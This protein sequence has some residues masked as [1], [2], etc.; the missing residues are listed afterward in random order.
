MTAED[1]D[2]EGNAEEKRPVEH[3]PLHSAPPNKLDPKTPKHS[4]VATSLGDFSKVASKSPRANSR[5]E[6][7]SADADWLDIQYA[8][9]LLLTSDV[10]LQKH[11]DRKKLQSQ[12]KKVHH[13]LAHDKVGD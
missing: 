10:D 7:R 12:L 3:M 5:H 9:G 8:P 13:Q 11:L 1:F 2:E 4:K 6:T